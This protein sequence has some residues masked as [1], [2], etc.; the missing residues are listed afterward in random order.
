[1][2]PLDSQNADPDSK[3]KVIAG[4]IFLIVFI[5]V[6]QGSNSPEQ[7]LHRFFPD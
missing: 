4:A 6:E 3:F 2:S 7:P 5:G 1:M